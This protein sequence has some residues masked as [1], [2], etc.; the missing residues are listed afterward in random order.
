MTIDIFVLKGDI[1]RE[2]RSGAFLFLLGIYTS[3]KLMTFWVKQ[4]KQW[5]NKRNAFVSFIMRV[6]TLSDLQ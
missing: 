3:S 6:R 1:D 4:T 5:E 2:T